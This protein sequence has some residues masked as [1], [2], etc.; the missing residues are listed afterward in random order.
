MDKFKEIK[1][2]NKE[3]FN[4]VKGDHKKQSRLGYSGLGHDFI[5]ALTVANYALLIAPDF[6][7]GEKAWVAGLCHNTDRIFPKYLKEELEEHILKYLNVTNFSKE[8]K[9]EILE[10]ILNHDQENDEKGSIVKTTLQ[11]SDRLANLGLAFFIRAGQHRFDKLV[12]DPKFVQKI[13]KSNSYKDP[14]TVLH[15]IQ[16]ALEW[17]PEDKEKDPRFCLR[18]S[19]AIELGRPLFKYTREGLNLLYKQVKDLNLDDEDLLVDS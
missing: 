13:D 14:K 16:S 11:D 5:H 3:L 18:L 1:N 8:D 17:D 2:K 7:V 9:E 10:A 12:F 15:D 19:K 4:L 6:A